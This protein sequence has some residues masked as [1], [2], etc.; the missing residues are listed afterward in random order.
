[1]LEFITQHRIFV[2]VAGLAIA[3]G[4][5][6][7]LTPSAPTS[8]LSSDGGSGPGQDVVDTLR[9]LDAVKLD[10]TLFTEPTFSSL[11]DFSTEIVPEPVGRPNPFAPL[12]SAAQATATSTKAAQIF[13]PGG[14]K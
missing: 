4:V 14:R 2:V 10:G 3:F 11:K 7:A 6:Y 13:A 9:E 5:W 12:T 1:M 8:A